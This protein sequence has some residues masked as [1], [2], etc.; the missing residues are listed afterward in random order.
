[1]F[2]LKLNAKTRIAIGQSGLVVTLVLLAS[3]VGLVPDRE[4]AVRDGRAALAEMIAINSSALVTQQDLHRLEAELG[5]AVERNED[6]LSAGLRQASGRLLATVGRHEQNWSDTPG[7]YSSDTQVSVP[8]W[9]GRSKWGRVELRFEPLRQ[10]GWMG[11]LADPFIHL[12]VFLGISTLLIFYLYL[13]RMLRHLDPS[14]AIPGR[15]RS[16]L[17]TMAEGL[18]VLDNKERIALANQAFGRVVDQDPEKLTGM[19]VADFAWGGS[20]GELIPVDRHPWNIALREGRPQINQTVKLTLP[21]G[22]SHT[23]MINCSPVLGS[24][25]K[26]A[27]VLVSFDD[28]TE[29][30]Q[31]EIELLKS[32]EEAEAANQAK[33]AFLANMSHEIRTPMNAILGFTELLK[34]GFGRDAEDNR[35][36]LETIHSSGKHLLELINDILDLSKV[37]AGRME[38][39][40]LRFQPYAVIQEVVTVLGVKAREKGIDLDFQIQGDVPDSI[41][42]DPARM[43]QIV[44]NLVGNA[45]KFTDRGGVTVVVRASVKDG[46]LRFAF[47][48]ADTGV[49][50]KPEALARI[51]EAFVQADTSTTR[52]FGGTG[53]GLS[54]SQK[55]ARALGGDITVTSTLGEG[56][57]FSVVVNGGKDADVEWLDGDEVLSAQSSVGVEKHASWVFPKLRVLVVDDGPENRELVKL[58]LEEFGISVDE[59]GN[60]RAGADMA[61]KGDY[62]V[63]YMDIQMPVMDGFSATRLLREK[64]YET[65]IIALT[66]NAMKGFEQQ[67]LDAGYTG[68]FSKPIDIDKFVAELAERVGAEPADET[69]LE[70]QGDVAEAP[71]EATAT[72]LAETPRLPPIRSSLPDEQERFAKLIR[73]FVDRLREQMDAI[74]QAWSERDFEQLAKLAHWLKGAGGTVGFDVFTEPAREFEAAAKLAD[75]DQAER[76]LDELRGLVGR[77]VAPG[78]EAVDCGTAQPEPGMTLERVPASVGNPQVASQRCESEDTGSEDESP[79]VSRLAGNARLNSAIDKFVIRLHEQYEEMEQAFER[80]DFESLAALAHWLKGAAGTVGFD[81]FTEPALE[82]EEKAKA[83]ELEPLGVVLGRIGTLVKRVQGVDQGP[84]TKKAPDR[85]ASSA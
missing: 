54:I 76:W 69:D 7:E 32:K 18:L 30:E 33:S 5:L 10:S 3:F 8:I 85:I 82:L 61:L 26:Y 75:A 4:T 25:G 83:D 20:D 16:A 15:V 12:T 39:E 72:P 9:A 81:D 37:E 74:E 53:L 65:P 50:M 47:D 17:D 80:Q 60:G 62:D 35:K 24:G 19:P 29:L 55:F 42:S 84:I 77:V 79:I 14:Q 64:G 13:G 36:Y 71:N 2:G 21:D 56:S 45:I 27:G 31:K 46:E 70:Q 34:R 48:V 49:G 67:C 58:V 68:Y 44:T 73:R 51:F 38:I 66:A 59:A 11:Y 40:E 22:N 78:E 23:F 43:R 1:M 28:V 57:V 52:K 6:L 41:H 63:V